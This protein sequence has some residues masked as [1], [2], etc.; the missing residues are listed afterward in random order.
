MEEEEEEEQAAAAEEQLH[1]Q[2]KLRIL[3]SSRRRGAS[4][5]KSEITYY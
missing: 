1:P 3:G 2:R 5:M 4:E